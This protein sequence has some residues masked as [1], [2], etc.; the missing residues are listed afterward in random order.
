MIV[1]ESFQKPL[2]LFYLIHTHHAINA[3][4]F[5]KST[6]STTRLV[7]LFEFFEAARATEQGDKNQ[8]RIVVRAYSSDSG[9]GERKAIFEKFKAREIQMY[10]LPFSHLVCAL[11]SSK[12]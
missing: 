5:T 10:V 3:L 8:Q 1:C 4:V 6:E 11:K 7:R 2:V 9:V 12:K